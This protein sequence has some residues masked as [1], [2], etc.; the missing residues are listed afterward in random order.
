MKKLFFISLL[1]PTL[2]FANS[3]ATV[4][5]EQPRIITVYQRQCELKEVLVEYDNRNGV[6]GGLIG[7]AIGTQIGGGSG[8]E[9]ATVVG[10]IT[11]TNIARNRSR[12]WRSSSNRTH[13][14]RTEFRNICND[15]PVQVESGKIVTFE[16]NGTVF[17]KIIE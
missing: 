3:S 12:I 1:F 4:I 2:V 5:S 16:Y 15:V 14:Y 10:A 13:G 7:A 9:I 17:T 6:L 8:R 11:G